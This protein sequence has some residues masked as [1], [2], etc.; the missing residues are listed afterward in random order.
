MKPNR[1]ELLQSM[2]DDGSEDPFVW[3][4]RAMELRRLERT[5]EALAAYRE[6]VARFPRYVPTYLMAGQV[7]EQLGLQVE[8]RDLFEAGIEVAR[9]SGDS[10]AAAELS[11]ALE[12]LRR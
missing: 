6:V 7:A 10:H 8:A 1:L 5:E 4:A 3:Y 2:I 11:A 12:S 9:A